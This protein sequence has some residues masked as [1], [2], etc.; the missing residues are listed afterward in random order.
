MKREYTVVNGASRMEECAEHIRN[1]FAVEGYET[2]VL[3]VNDPSEKGLLVQVRNENGGSSGFW[4][5][6][7]GLSTCATLKLAVR[8]DNLELA[9]M[10]GKWLDKA[11][12]NIVSWVVLWPLFFTSSIGM[13]KQKQ[14]LDRLFM[15]GVGAFASKS[16]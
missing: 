3:T 12:V 2:Q 14:L 10:G 16:A 8:G 15:E 4:K 7:T 5:S 6:V 13:W 11:A 9:V 1:T